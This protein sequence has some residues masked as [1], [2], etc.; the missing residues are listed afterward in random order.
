[1]IKQRTVLSDRKSVGVIHDTPAYQYFPVYRAK[2]PFMFSSLSYFRRRIASISELPRNIMAN[3][4]RQELQTKLD[5]Q[6]LTKRNVMIIDA[7]AISVKIKYPQD[8]KRL[9]PSALE[10]GG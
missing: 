8:T 6:G 7:T 9:N 5:H 3:F 4:V 10:L 2:A 1:M